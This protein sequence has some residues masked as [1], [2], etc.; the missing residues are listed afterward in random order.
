M[1]RVVSHPFG[2]LSAGDSTWGR[3]AVSSFPVLVRCAR[4]FRATVRAPWTNTSTSS[5]RSGRYRAQR[6][7]LPQRRAA[8]CAVSAERDFRPGGSP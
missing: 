8:V 5:A 6:A 4:L 3:S 7:R 1:V 2:S